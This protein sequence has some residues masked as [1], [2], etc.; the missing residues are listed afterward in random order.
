MATE[1]HTT[2]SITTP[3][4]R[5]RYAAIS[6]HPDCRACHNDRESWIESNKGRG[7]VWKR[8]KSCPASKGYFIVNLHG[9]GYKKTITVHT[10]ILSAFGPK[11]PGPEYQCAHF[12][13]D[14][15]N[16]HPDNLRWATAKEN[17]ADAI[18]N[19]RIRPARGERHCMS[20]LSDAEIREIRRKHASGGVTHAALGRE[21]KVSRS[22]ITMIIN[23]TKR[24][25][26]E[27]YESQT[28][29]RITVTV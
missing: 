18:R 19:G 1:D 28:V 21:F 10:I 14:K 13:D 3:T 8:L 15:N 16:N 6:G 9:N 17:K 23:R 26:Q 12:D 25:T 29:A 20:K 4:N 24:R 27:E 7:G 11:K 2:E 5:I 22:L